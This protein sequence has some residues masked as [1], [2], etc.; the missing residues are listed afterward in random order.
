[1]KRFL[2]FLCVY[3][4]AMYMS[5]QDSIKTIPQA[6]KVQKK[7]KVDFSL[8][9]AQYFVQDLRNSP[10]EPTGI[11][12]PF[13]RWQFSPGF[14]NVEW[15]GASKKRTKSAIYYE[16]SIE[17]QMRYKAVIAN[18]KNHSKDTVRVYQRLLLRKD[19]QSYNK[20]GYIVTLIPDTSSMSGQCC[21]NFMKGKNREGFS[22]LQIYTAPRTNAL[23]RVNRYDKGK[24]IDGIFIGRTKAEQAKNTIR[25][26]ELLGGVGILQAELAYAKGYDDYDWEWNWND[27]VFIANQNSQLPLMDKE[28]IAAMDVN[29]NILSALPYMQIP[30]SDSD[31]F[32]TLFGVDSLPKV[33]DKLYT[34][35]Q[36]TEYINAG[37]NEDLIP[38]LYLKVRIPNTDLL[39]CAATYGGVTDYSTDQL[40]VVDMFGNIK[41][42]LE[43]TVMNAGIAVKQYRITEDC[44]VIVC[45][46]HPTSPTSISFEDFMATSSPIE[47]YKT[48]RRYHINAEGQFVREAT[49]MFPDKSYTEKQLV[50]HEIWDL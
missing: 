33:S 31:G 3:V 7:V 45:Q 42:S 43:G 36:C 17:P 1:M 44:K 40:F 32:P 49:K 16:T 28:K 18:N 46:L 11:Q 8:D 23:V 4:L 37:Y 29:P 38:A 41:S 30:C 24:L 5:A 39:L 50:E 22:G 47:A 13:V 10:A 19:L 12:K 6:P 14:F 21:E 15:D 2:L 34:N 25:A 27:D 48:E 26:E 35:L 20:Y 9:E